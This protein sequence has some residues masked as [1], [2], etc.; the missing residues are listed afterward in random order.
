MPVELPRG[1]KRIKHL[2]EIQPPVGSA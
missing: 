2:F 1:T